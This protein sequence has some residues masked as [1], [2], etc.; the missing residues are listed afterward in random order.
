LEDIYLPFKPKRRTRAAIAREKGL[1]PLAKIIMQQN[2]RD[3]E[4]K[5]LS[6][7]GEAVESTEDALAGARDII[8][9]WVNENEKARTVVRRTFDS[10]AVISCKVVKGKEEEAAK[11]H[12]YFDWKETL[13]KCPSHRLL[14]AQG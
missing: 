8:A 7:V 5:A 3:I 2:E 1:E 4:H 6:F 14:D 10:E 9:E 13:K 11:Y 12:D